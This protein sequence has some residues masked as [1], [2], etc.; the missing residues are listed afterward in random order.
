MR[1]VSSAAKDPLG[2]ADPW[3]SEEDADVSGLAALAGGKG[4]QV[5]VYH[6]HDDWARTGV[7][8]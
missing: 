8:R 2:Y 3:G 4:L 1:L 7:A 6:H 5:L